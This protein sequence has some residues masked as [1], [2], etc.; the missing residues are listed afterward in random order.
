[1]VVNFAL[2]EFG[3]GEENLEYKENF[4]SLCIAHFM[5]LKREKYHHSTSEDSMYMKIVSSSSSSD[6]SEDGQNEKSI[7]Q[8]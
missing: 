1:M 6:E 8:Q 4:G 7:M 3:F 5:A 2:D